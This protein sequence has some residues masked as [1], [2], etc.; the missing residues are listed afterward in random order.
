MID[1]TAHHQTHARLSHEPTDVSAKGILLFIVALGALI[2]LITGGLWLMYNR[3]AAEQARLKRSRF[4]LAVADRGRPLE[5]RL[6][7]QPRL[8]GLDPGSLIHSGVA[9]WPSLAPAQRERDEL[10]LSKYG[11]VDT[12]A[13]VAQIPIER[14]IELLAGKLPVRKETKEAAAVRSDAGKDKP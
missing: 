7:P 8:E 14:A 6:P 2:V 3:L 1:T 13:G 4:P 5:D 11:W 12:S 10:A 9:G